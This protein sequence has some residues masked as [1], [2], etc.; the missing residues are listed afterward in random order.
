MK[1]IFSLSIILLVTFM[2]ISSSANADILSLEPPRDIDIND[3]RIW[4]PI[5]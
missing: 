3:G 1:K 2:L 5:E 4:A